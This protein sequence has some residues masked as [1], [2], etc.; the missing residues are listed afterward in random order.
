MSY[1]GEQIKSSRERKYL[2]LEKLSQLIELETNLSV[3]RSTLQRIETS[4]TL[5]S[6]DVTCCIAHVLGIDIIDLYRNTLLK[7]NEKI[8][9]KNKVGQGG[10]GYL[11]KILEQF[12]LTPRE[13]RN[14]IKF[15]LEIQEKMN[16]ITKIN[17]KENV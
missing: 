7:S 1:L 12:N 14:I 17:K 11:K 4:E 2:T 8:K 16:D 9:F 3:S 5:P 15:H 10:V 13:A 6:F